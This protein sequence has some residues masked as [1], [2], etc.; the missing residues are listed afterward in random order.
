MASITSCL[1]MWLLGS[2]P[3]Y[4]ADLMTL[5]LSSTEPSNPTVPHM[6]DFLNAAACAADGLS[7]A[8]DRPAIANAP[9][10]WRVFLIK[11]L[12]CMFYTF[13]VCN[14]KAQM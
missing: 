7:P 5:H 4:P 6:T 8:S 1:S 9:E 10:V 12:R 13:Y 14:D 2:I 11:S 3:V